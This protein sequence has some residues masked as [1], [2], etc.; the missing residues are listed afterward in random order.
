MLRPA[1]F[2]ARHHAI[3]CLTVGVIRPVNYVTI[4]GSQSTAHSSAIHCRVALFDRS[5]PDWLTSARPPSYPSFL[6]S[7]L[8]KEIRAWRSGGK[9]PRSRESTEEGRKEGLGTEGR[10]EGA[11]RK[12][13]GAMTNMVLLSE[14]GIRNH[15]IHPN[16]PYHYPSKQFCI[17]KLAQGSGMGKPLAPEPASL[18][19]AA[20]HAAQAATAATFPFWLAAA[21]RS[22]SSE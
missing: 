7:S 3:F 6:A 17:R 20:L 15:P 11:L 16:H 9:E 22:L 8:S 4:K 12:R 5:S 21:L 14:E 2:L 18:S 19:T 10:T 13:Q 1:H